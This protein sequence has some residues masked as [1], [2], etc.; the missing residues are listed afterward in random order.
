M[1]ARWR[2]REHDSSHFDTRS[3]LWYAPGQKTPAFNSDWCGVQIVVKNQATPS[4][5]AT[6]RFDCKQL[7]ACWLISK[8]SGRS[9]RRVRGSAIC[10]LALLTQLRWTSY[11]AM[12]PPFQPRSPITTVSAIDLVLGKLAYN[13]RRCH[14]MW[15]PS[16]S[17]DMCQGGQRSRAGRQ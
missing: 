11:F 16:D 12:D 7:H 15:D 4:L 17:A 10:S 9:C 3:S 5:S 14:L 2:I 8:L 13:V 6:V 1:S